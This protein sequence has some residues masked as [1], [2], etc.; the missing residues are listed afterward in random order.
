MAATPPIPGPLWDRIPPDV[1]AAL[2]AAFD[3][4]E[5]RITELEQRLGRNSTNSSRPP[6]SDSPSVKRRPPRAPSG[7]R[8]GGQPGHRAH[9]RPLVPP[10]RVDR[11]T[12]VRP[13]HCRRC[14]HGLSGADPAPRRHQV[15][16]LPPVRPTV[17][18]YRLHRLTC[19]R[20]GQATRAARPPG[21]PA[22]AFG[23]RLRAVLGLLAGGYRLSKRSVQQAAFDLF[24]LS[25]STGMIARSERQ[26]AEELEGPVEELRAHVRRASWAHIDET[27]WRQGGG[28]AWL[29][30]AVTRMA[31]VFTI[32]PTR[33][34][35]VARGLLGTAP[36]KVAVCD[37]FRSYRWVRR[38]QL[39]WAHLRREFQAMIDRG[40]APAGVGE[41]LLECS[42]RLFHN[43]HRVRDG[44]MSRPCFARWAD[45]LRWQF[46]LGLER[47]AACGCGK[48]AATCRELLDDEAHLWTFVRVAGVEPT[49]N[50]AERALR[51][52]VLYRKTSGGT[53]SEAGSR[54]VERVLSVVATCRQRGLNALEYLSRCYQA[55][56]EAAPLPSLLAE[57]AP[58]TGVA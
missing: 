12:E 40:G 15:A 45:L 35:E 20:C 21:V 9:F 2:A 37:R 3:R 7:K 22:G 13:A 1:Q 50:A 18:E 5:R 28:K 57:P 53:D 43:W 38:R 6:S 41:R 48:T 36:E 16:E 44:T 47:G 33:G 58:A 55:H 25:I 19:P 49:N 14:G 30:V 26:G 54:F 23:P 32:A 51:P 27:S 8:R 39:C 24:G 46:L 4:L 31:T 42:D 29:W 11:I 17:R 10:E 56:A 52:A 34:A